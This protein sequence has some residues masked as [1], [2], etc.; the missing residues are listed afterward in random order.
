MIYLFQII[1]NILV[2]VTDNLPS[3]TDQRANIFHT[4]SKVMFIYSKNG[5]PISSIQCSYLLVLSGKTEKDCL[6]VS[7]KGFS[8]TASYEVYC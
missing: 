4:Q 6:L 2:K 8:M 5:N 3:V 1:Q 7:A